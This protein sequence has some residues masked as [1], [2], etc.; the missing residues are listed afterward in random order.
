MALHKPKLNLKKYFHLYSCCYL[1]K[2][3]KRS[4]LI[5]TQRGGY[6]FIP[7]DLYDILTVHQ[8]KT[9]YQIYDIYGENNVVIINSYFN[10]LI[11]Y[12]FGEFINHKMEEGFKP[13]P[14]QIVTPGVISNAI[15]DVRMSLKIDFA[16][17]ILDL[18]K[19]GCT[20]L[21]IRI[22]EISTLMVLDEIAN[23]LKNSP[24]NFVEIL[25]N[26]SALISFAYC[27]AFLRDNYA[28]NLI[29]L[30]GCRS[31]KV[32]KLNSHQSIATSKVILKSRDQCGVVKPRYFSSTLK[33]Y[34]ESGEHNS[35]LFKKISIDEDGYIKNCPSFSLHFGKFG[36]V[37]LRDILNMP[38]FQQIGR[39][40]KSQISICKVCEF[41]RICPDCRVY[42]V[43]S[44]S[45][46]SKPSKCDY[47]PYNATW[48]KPIASLVFFV[49]LC[50]TSLA[51]YASEM[52]KRYYDSSIYYYQEIIPKYRDSSPERVVIAE[53]K[54][55]YYMY[56]YIDTI[57]VPPLDDDRRKIITWL[58]DIFSTRDEIGESKNLFKYVSSK[59]SHDSKVKSWLLGR[60]DTTRNFRSREFLSKYGDELR[61]ILEDKSNYKNKQLRTT[62]E[63]VWDT[64]Q[65][66]RRKISPDLTND[67]R[68][69]ESDLID[70]MLFYDRKNLAIV[71]NVLKNYG[72]PAPAEVGFKASEAIFLVLHHA[73]TATF[74]KYYNEISDAYK[75]N[76]ISKGNYELYIDRYLSRKF[77][78]QLYGTQMYYDSI[79]KK[80]IPFPIEHNL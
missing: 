75:E 1:T 39:I 70:S 71:E 68:I 43:D 42:T 80:N 48:I 55:I 44:S 12:D 20:G 46:Y 52:Y 61:N 69:L 31:D 10:Y 17:A 26:H 60:L 37:H 41:R 76:K 29:T 5:D 40:D 15:I 6:N 64:D 22:Y 58:S 32:H 38:D 63:A 72:W 11:D 49:L 67:N 16:K 62:L 27:K 8:N 54:A 79:L 53:N 3:F 78:Y 50:Y 28:V 14:E 34:L 7:N 66:F 9:L 56:K 65:F 77:G 30:F 73:D 4:I 57:M 47:D 59:Y 74:F 18:E 35:C 13:I 51:Q 33:N 23:A 21:Q 25:I 24:I 19:L 45:P 36:E 2:G